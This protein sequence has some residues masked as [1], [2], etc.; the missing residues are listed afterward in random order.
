LF[1]L[2]AFCVLLF[3]VL[4]F[5]DMYYLAISR[6][7]DHF[8]YLSLIPILALL[9]AVSTSTVSPAS[10]SWFRPH[11]SRFMLHARQFLA[12]AVVLM[13]A[14]LSFSR[15]KVMATDEGL[16][17]DTL[18]KN[19]TAWTAHNNLACILAEKHDFEQAAQHF[20]A[21]LE[22]NPAN[23][24]AHANLGAL[25][26]QRGDFAEAEKHFLRSLQLKPNDGDAQRMYATFLAARGRGVD[27][28]AHYQ[29]ALRVQADTQT[30]LDYA[31][32]LHQSGNL[33]E[34]A[35]QYRVVLEREP[36]SLDALN[37]LAWAL[38]TSADANLRNGAEAVRLAE[39][40]CQLTGFKEAVPV[41]TLAAAYAE[42]SRFEEAAATAAKAITLAN[43][44]GNRQFAAVNEQLLR[45]YRSGRP[46]RERPQ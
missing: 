6:V 12:A 30:R 2:G 8:A 26:E 44:S 20:E 21:S 37:N 14:F 10:L 4:G 34:M 5:F 15:A 36:T 29:E 18:T 45:L 39:R 24:G 7:S 41:G 43:A 40:A 32:L 35:A 11:I 19:T 27:A 33:R 46:F 16:W 22:Y 28:L 31:A 1:A 38:A 23:A 9:S 42:T 13:L 25:L 17:L 3:P